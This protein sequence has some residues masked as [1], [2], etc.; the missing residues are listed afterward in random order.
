M[1]TTSIQPTHSNS[2]AHNL[3]TFVRWDDDFG[4]PAPQNHARREPVAVIAMPSPSAGPER[5]GPA[6]PAP[7]PAS[8]PAFQPRRHLRL[9]VLVPFEPEVFAAAKDPWAVRTP[10]DLLRLFLPEVSVSLGLA[11]VSGL[12][13]GKLLSRWTGAIEVW[14]GPAFYLALVTLHLGALYIGGRG[15]NSARLKSSLRLSV[16]GLFLL[17]LPHVVATAVLSAGD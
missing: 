6:L 17:L 4:R 12:L 15:A 9:P 13:A 16:L 11:A 8:R 2:L 1:P 3:Q 10:L 7:E 5:P 14:W